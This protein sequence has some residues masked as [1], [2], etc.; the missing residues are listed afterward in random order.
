M[1]SSPSEEA[2]EE[3]EG[4]EE[5]AED[6]REAVRRFPLPIASAASADRLGCYVVLGGARNPDP[7][8]LPSDGAANATTPSSSPSASYHALVDGNRLPTPMPCKAE[9]IVKGDSREY[10]VG[11]ASVIA[12][13]TRDRLMR[14]YDVMFPEYELSRH[15]GYP[16]A[17]H[18]ASV[19]VHGAS[20]IHRRTF[21]PLKHMRFD[22]EGRVVVKEEDGE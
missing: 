4:A 14:E 6:G 19:T 12:K 8:P 15:K 10:A 16:T 13:V 22:G 3:E 7:A 5:G 11:A 21:A 1:R 9:A 18:R 17:A 20:P 2:E